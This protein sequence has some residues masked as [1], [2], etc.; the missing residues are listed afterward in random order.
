MTLERQ[1][2][3]EMYDISILAVICS[4]AVFYRGY[5]G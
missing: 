2:L 3:E 1:C 4:S 5:Y